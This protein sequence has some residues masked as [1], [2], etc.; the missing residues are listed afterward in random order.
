MTILLIDP[1]PSDRERIR[2]LLREAF[3]EPVIESDGSD[4]EDALASP[5]LR[6]VLLEQRLKGTTGLQV[7]ERLRLERPEVGAIMVTGHGDEEIAVAGLK[8][9]L[10]DY[11]PKHRLAR[12]LPSVHQALASSQPE[13]DP[14]LPHGQHLDKI[15]HALNNALTP[16]RL[17][18]DLLRRVRDETA[19]QTL[20]DSI[21]AGVH[22]CVA[23]LR[24]VPEQADPAPPQPL[25][26]VG[27]APLILVAEDDRGIREAARTAL[28]S[29]GYRVLTAGNGAEALALHKQQR[30]SIAAVV[31]DLGMPVLDGLALIRALRAVDAAIPILTA[32]G[33]PANPGMLQELGLRAFL[34]KPYTTHQLLDALRRVLMPS[35]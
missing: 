12:L 5:E 34:L 17:G 8:A 11:I 2:E 27:E 20:I 3:T 16:I 9:G 29:N 28:E 23:L 22:R 15:A 21:V 19:R 25:H 14:P 31:V 6:L 7:I 33:L 4:L 18:A 32:S 10:L 26:A 13:L 1:D 35:E 30:D 24:Q